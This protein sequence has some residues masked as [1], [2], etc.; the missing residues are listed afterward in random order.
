[1]N[2]IERETLIKKKFQS[3]EWK[4]RTKK[5]GFEIHHKNGT[6]LAK[7]TTRHE[8]EKLALTNTQGE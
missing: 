7:A 1:M 8:A 4:L 5:T 3:G 6:V 2:N